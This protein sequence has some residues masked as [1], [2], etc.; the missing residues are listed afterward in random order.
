[1][2][3]DATVLQVDDVT[4]RASTQVDEPDFFFNSSVGRS[5][6]PA[7]VPSRPKDR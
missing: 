4:L 5:T 3:D 7:E 6:R 2:V 1:M